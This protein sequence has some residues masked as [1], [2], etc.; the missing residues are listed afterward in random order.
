MSHSWPG[1]A[2]VSSQWNCKRWPG[3]G[4]LV[5][6]TETAVRTTRTA[7][8]DGI[9]SLLL[10]T[11]YQFTMG[12][13]FIR[14]R[15]SPV[16]SVGPDQ[17]PAEDQK[18]TQIGA[19]DVTPAQETM[20]AEKLDVVAEKEVAEVSCLPDEKCVSMLEAAPEPD[21]KPN[22]EACVV[23]ATPEGENDLSSMSSSPSIELSTPDGTPQPYQNPT[24]VQV[25]EGPQD[26]AVAVVNS[27]LEPEKPE[28]E[29]EPAVAP[30]DV[31]CA[32]D[33]KQREESISE[34]LKK[35]SLN[36]GAE[37]DLTD[38]TSTDTSS[39]TIQVM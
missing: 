34:S 39:N 20:P 11:S 24:E 33:M 5:F 1:N 22:P 17:K 19:S 23:E 21:P 2:L 6:P 13:K 27:T 9:K 30:A 25:S 8:M 38:D 15:E 26:D 14:K 35:L 29:P 3:T 16:G 12:N 37:P 7:W 28:E 32:G 10:L 4:L 31:V 36:A 18:T